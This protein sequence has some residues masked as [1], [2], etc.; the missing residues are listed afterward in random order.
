MASPPRVS[1]QREGTQR[2]RTHPR[3][4]LDLAWAGSAA[5]APVAP[6][7]AGLAPRRGG[8]AADFGVWRSEIGHSWDPVLRSR[9]RRASL[10]VLYGAEW[11]VTVD[12]AARRAV[13][14]VRDV[15]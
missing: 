1:A 13:A 6:A 3:I 2:A 5:A 12:G 7:W 11:H 14:H 10:V 9:F 4:R 8:R 15:G